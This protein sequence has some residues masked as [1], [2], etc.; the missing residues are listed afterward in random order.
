MITPNDLNAL[1]T[2]D[3]NDYTIADIDALKQAFADMS[4]AVLSVAQDTPY[5]DLMPAMNIEL[6][7]SSHPMNTEEFWAVDGHTTNESE[8]IVY[9]VGGFH[10]CLYT[11]IYNA[12]VAFKHELGKLAKRTTPY[13]QVWYISLDGDKYLSQPMKQ[14]AIHT[15]TDKAS[16]LEFK[17]ALQA[18]DHI[19]KVRN[20]LPFQTVIKSASVGYEL[21]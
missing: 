7:I 8:R 3:S 11:A 9:S 21:V 5:H 17:T 2:K 20:M 10:S 4:Q 6:K 1:L 16:R 14:V 15:T 13:K 18:E 19:K 12:S